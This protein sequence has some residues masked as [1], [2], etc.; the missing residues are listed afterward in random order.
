MRRMK[1]IAA[2]AAAILL[3]GS[4][5]LCVQGKGQEEEKV[6]IG[7]SMASELASYQ[8]GLAGKMQEIAEQSDSMKWNFIMQTGMRTNRRSSFGK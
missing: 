6:T 3:S 4:L 2:A 7:I 8:K 1:R 5:P